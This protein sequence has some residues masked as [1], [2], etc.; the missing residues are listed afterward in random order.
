MNLDLIVIFVNDSSLIPKV[1]KEQ[2]RQNRFEALFIANLLGSVGL[3]FYLM[4]EVQRT[5]ACL[6]YCLYVSVQA[7]RDVFHA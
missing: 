2:K 4:T 5:C 6:T 3:A 7:S 1:M